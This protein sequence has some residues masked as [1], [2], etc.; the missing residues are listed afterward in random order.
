MKKLQTAALLM[1]VAFSFGMASACGVTYLEPAG[2]VSGNVW[3]T[4]SGYN[5]DEAD[6]EGVEV[7]LMYDA[8]GTGEYD[9][10]YY[11]TGVESE[12]TEWEVPADCGTTDANGEFN[13]EFVDDGEYMVEITDEDGSYNDVDYVIDVFFAEDA[14]VAEDGTY[15]EAAELEQP[16]G[17]NGGTDNPSDYED[18][19]TG[20]G[21]FVRIVL[22]WGDASDYDAY[23]SF[24]RGDYHHLMDDVTSP[25]Y[26]DYM[27]LQ[28][29]T[30]PR[31]DTT[32]M[33]SDFWDNSTT[34]SGPTNDA[35]SVKLTYQSDATTQT[36][37]ETGTGA[38]AFA[39]TPA[40]GIY[41]ADWD[42]SGSGVTG[43]SMNLGTRG[44]MY[45]HYNQIYTTTSTPP[46]AESPYTYSIDINGDSTYTTD[47]IAVGLDKDA[48]CGSPDPDTC[49]NG[50][51]ET[52]FLG[53]IPTNNWFE[54]D[55]TTG[56]SSD[57]NDTALDWDGGSGVTFG[58]EQTIEAYYVGLGQYTV[59][60]YSNQQ[61]DAFPASRYDSS[62]AT[63]VGSVSAY[64]KSGD[65]LWTF[66]IPEGNT[67]AGTTLEF[68]NW[69]PFYSVYQVENLD[70]DTTL[71]ENVKIVPAGF[72][73]DILTR[74]G[75][76]GITAS[77]R[78]RSAK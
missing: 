75:L 46:S 48:Y 7:D 76:G 19:T 42:F 5:D 55:G 32:G 4:S 20:E 68:R 51:P 23:W 44:V 67:D 12:E 30:V 60:F 45:W 63:T 18:P 66:V 26:P 16:L 62:F 43:A 13:C 10:S 78:T 47:E 38:G 73:N 1:T 69:R 40:N 61:D 58:D 29:S 27:T 59:S 28:S 31:F 41:P 35:G 8:E 36:L 53:A 9:D 64:A 71:E 34:T 37:T 49:A 57:F 17:V 3:H 33:P 24:P 77:L 65:R 6:V 25:F 39:I 15:E 74:N 70:G 50:G 52:I 21:A 56:T 54:A 22:T 11:E 2:T 14:A 72:D